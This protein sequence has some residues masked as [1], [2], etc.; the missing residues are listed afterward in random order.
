MYELC[1]IFVAGVL[2]S[3]GWRLGALIFEGIQNFV[4]DTPDGIEQIRRYKEKKR[5][6]VDHHLYYDIQK[7]S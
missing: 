6:R 4:L 7:R 1:M 5:T 2:L 3:I